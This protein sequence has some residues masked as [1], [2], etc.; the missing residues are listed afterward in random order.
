ML[1]RMWE[2]DLT[3][4]DRIRLNSRVIGQNGVCLPSSQES[5]Y[6]KNLVNLSKMTFTSHLFLIPY[7]SL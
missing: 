1:K 5:K 2:G 3:K 6:N 7:I 4:E